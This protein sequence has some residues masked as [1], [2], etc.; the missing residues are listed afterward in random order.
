MVVTI[1]VNTADSSL[2]NHLVAVVRHTWL[3]CSLLASCH[4]R[5]VIACFEVRMLLLSFDSRSWAVAIHTLKAEALAIDAVHIH[6][7]V[8]LGA[9]TMVEL[10]KLML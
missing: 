4:Q 2:V 6:T 9:S 8:S 10:V 5:L 3:H 7:T 1:V